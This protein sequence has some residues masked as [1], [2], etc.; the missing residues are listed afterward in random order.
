MQEWLE[1]V[2]NPND[3]HRHISHA[4]GLYPGNQ[5]SPYKNPLLFQAAKNTLLQRGDEAT[6]WSIGWKINLWARLLDGNHAYKIIRNLFA[7]RT[8]P[9]LFDVHP[10]FQIDGNF[11][12]TA[13]VAE[14]L[15]Q[16]HDEALHLLPALPDEWRSGKVTGLKAR[17]GFTVDMEWKGG[18]LL[19]ARIKSG[20]GG[21][22]R[23]RSYIPLKGKGLTEAEDENTNRYYQN[24]DIKKPLMDEGLDAEY[25]M[26]YKKYE[27]DID[28]QAGDEYI[29][30]RM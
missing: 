26:L 5:I 21:K 8:Y 30:E 18:E 6:G 11:G 27:Y 7:G 13:G 9:N 12:Y 15:M 17:G 28:T 3:K 2:D 23:I 24:A 19:A 14:M 16:S 1:D 22:L 20:L 25:P 10:P 4:F 29:L